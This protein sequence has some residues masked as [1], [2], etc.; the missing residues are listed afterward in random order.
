[1]VFFGY[2]MVF[3]LTANPLVVL[4]LLIIIG[5]VFVLPLRGVEGKRTE[6]LFFAT[7]ALIRTAIV[8]ALVGGMLASGMLFRACLQ[9]RAKP[10]AHAL[11]WGSD[12]GRFEKTVSYRISRLRSKNV[13]PF[14]G[15]PFRNVE[16]STYSVGPDR[17]DGL[18]TV[19][20]DPT[21]GTIS[22]GDIKIQ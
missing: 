21:N 17:T 13:D 3:L 4:G 7:G 20:Y 1:M 14:S 8:W 6:L 10:I 5:L 11:L 15:V 2:L 9:L 18:L 16:G 12:V 19:K 22:A